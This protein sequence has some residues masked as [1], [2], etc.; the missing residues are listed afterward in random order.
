MIDF[1]TQILIT[2]YLISLSS[3][4]HTHTLTPSHSHTHTVPPTITQSF[5]ETT[6]NV[7][8]SVQLTCRAQGSSPLTWTWFRNKVMLTS[9]RVGYDQNGLESTLTIS[10]VEESDGGVYQCRVEQMTYRTMAAANEL[11]V[12]QSECTGPLHLHI[13]PPD[14]PSPLLPSSFPSSSPPL[15]LPLSH[16]PAHAQPYARSLRTV[17]GC[18]TCWCLLAVQCSSTA[19]PLAF[20]LLS[21]PGPREAHAPLTHSKVNSR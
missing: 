15:L 5:S 17:L 6:V 12:A 18:G 2:S 8:Q 7:T 10:R 21:S 20:L 19:L 3:H 13:P 9:A 11:L 1:G 4:S 14:S 16:T